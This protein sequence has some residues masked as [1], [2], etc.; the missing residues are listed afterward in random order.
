MS[1]DLSVNNLDTSFV[2]DPE[3]PGTIDDIRVTFDYEA[4]HYYD[5]ESVTPIYS[6]CETTPRF[7][8]EE[9]APSIAISED[10]NTPELSTILEKRG[11]RQVIPDAALAITL[12]GYS[13]ESYADPVCQTISIYL[14]FFPSALRELLLF[15]S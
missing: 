1:E 6:E 4:P 2:S 5:D 15:N 7:D 9:G 8:D 3:F 11:R 13:F 14:L 12:G 10:K